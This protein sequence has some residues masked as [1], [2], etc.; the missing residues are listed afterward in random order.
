MKTLPVITLALL[1]TGC[2]A[3]NPVRTLPAGSDAM[4][5]SIGAY[6]YEDQPRLPV[7]SLGYYG[8]PT[9]WLTVGGNIYPQLLFNATLGIEGT[10]M[11]R[12]I[13]GQEM[14]PELTGSLGTYFYQSLGDVSYRPGTSIHPFARVNGSSKISDKVMVF[15]GSE[16]NTQ[17]DLKSVA[18]TPS[19]GIVF[20][21]EG[22]V[23]AQV[24][25]KVLGL[26]GITDRQRRNESPIQFNTNAAVGLYFGYFIHDLFQKHN[27]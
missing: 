7:V 12:I 26:V 2:Y 14:A 8:A 22:T 3:T 24:E 15:L 11:F 10:A 16:W 4:T 1:L 19:A 25:A 6:I 13:K 18:M 23:S 27:L 20:S 17:S 21:N 5:L 9:D